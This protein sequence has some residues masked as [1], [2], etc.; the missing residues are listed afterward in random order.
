MAQDSAERPIIDLRSDTVTIPTPDML[1]A[2][3]EARVGDDVYGED[4][5]ANR[6]EAM[7]AELLGKE[8]AVF[9]PSGT[10][11]NLI[12]IRAQTQP[13]DEM[14]LDAE[15]HCYLYESGGYAQFAGLSARFIHAE[16]GIIQP[17]DIPAAVRGRNVHLPTSRLVVIENTHNRGGGSVYPVDTVRRIREVCQE[18]DL[19]LHMDGARLLHACVVTGASPSDY[20]QHV[21]SVCIALS[22]GLGCPVGSMVAGSA[23]LAARARRIRKALGGGM[24]QAGYLAAAGIYALEHNVERLHEDHENA[25]LLADGVRETSQLKLKW[26]P[27]ETNMVYFDVLPPLTT[28]ALQQTLQKEGVLIGRIHSTSFRAVTHIGIAR[29]DIERIVS[30]LQEHYG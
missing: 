21:D 22:K 19:A 30:I 24:R 25:R 16:R 3:M 15:S 11:A 14:I 10:M 2:M 4:P 9:V 27:P 7:T 17:E 23:E 1:R 26:D 13:G 28:A 29:E 12:C 20:S 8:A 6:L 18:H 5:D